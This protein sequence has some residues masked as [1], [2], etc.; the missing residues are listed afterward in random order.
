MV[1]VKKTFK[2]HATE[3]KGV[4]FRWG[5]HRATGKPERIFY[6]SYWRNGKRIEEVAGREKANEMTAYKASRL[7]GRKIDGEPSRQEQREAA[8]A[9]KA[10]ADGRWT[11]SKLFA[12]YKEQHPGK[13]LAPETSRF[14]CHILPAFGDKTPEEIAPLDVDR[15]RMNLL[16]KLEPATAFAILELL[17]R[18]VNFGVDRRLTSGLSFKIKM[19]TV[20]NLK[21]E[22]LNAEQLGRLLKV[23]RGERLEDD[24]PDYEPEAINPDARDIMLMALFTGMRRGELFRL[25]WDD[26]DMERGFLTIRNPK[27]GKDQ[28][29][30]LSDAAREL[31]EARPRRE[32]KHDEEAEAVEY[33]FPGRSGGKRTDV[34]KAL[35]KIR[36]RARLPEGFRPLHGLRHVFASALASSGEVDLFTLQRLLTHKSPTMTMRYAHLS[37]AALRRAAGV[38]GRLVQEVEAKGKQSEAS[39]E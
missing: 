11:I 21:T 19:P 8:K 27:G 28:S 32:K 5:T 2:R 29:I 16:K 12:E 6:I 22:N 31:L 4:Y 10:A 3:Y 14:N 17:R 30:P 23:L 18:L 36:E 39:G 37:D 24:P 20:N 9:A 13:K 33:V 1:E 7:R 25:T 34:K 35:Q 38:A 15:L 26:V